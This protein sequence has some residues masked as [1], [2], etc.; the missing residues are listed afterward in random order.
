MCTAVQLHPALAGATFVYS[1]DTNSMNIEYSKWGST[2]S[3]AAN[4]GLIVAGTTSTGEWEQRR[5]YHGSTGAAP[6]QYKGSTG[7]A[8]WQYRSSTMEVHGQYRSST[9]A[10]QE[11]FLQWQY[12]GSTIAVHGQHMRSTIAVHGQHMRST[13]AVQW[14]GIPWLYVQMIPHV[15]AGLSFR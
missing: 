4:Y 15:P 13:M 12:R 5:Q 6:W 9:V 1:T 3:T 11:Q 14:D 8:P 7:A 10:V 2:S